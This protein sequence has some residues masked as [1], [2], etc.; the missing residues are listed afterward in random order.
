[1]RRESSVD[2][3]AESTRLVR[4]RSSGE[5][6]TEWRRIARRRE[7]RGRE[8]RGR[9]GATLVADVEVEDSGGDSEEDIADMAE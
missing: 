3:V 5:A 7:A 8:A 6:E 4:V 9:G 2:M 1:M